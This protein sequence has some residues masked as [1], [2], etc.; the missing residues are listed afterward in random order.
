MVETDETE[1]VLKGAHQRRWPDPKRR[2]VT[3]SV[4]LGPH[5]TK[6][7]NESEGRGFGEF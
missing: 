4:S 1:T 2:F 3:G 5:I 6:T 7:R